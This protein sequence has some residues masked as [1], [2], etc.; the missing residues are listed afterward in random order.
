MKIC[1][2]NGAQFVVDAEGDLLK[3]VL[4]YHPFLIKPNHHELGELFETMITNAKKLSPMAKNSLKWERKMSLFHLA[5]K[6]PSL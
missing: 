4:P 2:E 6:G 3:K 1:S 5:G